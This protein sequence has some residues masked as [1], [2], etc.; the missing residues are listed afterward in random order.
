MASSNVPIN[1]N[2]SV[3][4]ASGRPKPACTRLKPREGNCETPLPSPTP[5]G[6]T[7]VVPVPATNQQDPV[8]D[9]PVTNSSAPKTRPG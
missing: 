5:E 4:A 6:Q 9:L 3:L 7:P 8:V 2:R 1:H